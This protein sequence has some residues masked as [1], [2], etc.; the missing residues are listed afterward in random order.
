MLTA[1][2]LAAVCSVHGCS[3]RVYRVANLPPE[4]H[5]PATMDLEAINLS[6][7]ADQSISAEVIQPGDVLEVTMVTNYK[8]FATTATPVRVAD[9]GCIVVPLVG[10]MGVSGLEI[11]Q[12]EQLINTQSI[13]RGIFRN[14]CI[15][16]MMKQ[17]HTSKVTV[18]GAVNNPGTHALPRGSTSLM[19][20]LLAAGGLNKDA[21]TEVEIRHT[22]SR[23]IARAM[24]QP[25]NP[26][27]GADGAASPV[28]YEQAAVPAVTKVDLAAAT[29]GAMKVPDLGDGDVVHV[30][31]RTLPPVHVIGLVRT[32][33]EFPYPPD[34]E[35]RVLDALALAGGCSNPVAEK[36]LV[37]RHPPNS[38]EPVRIEISIQAAKNGRDN[39]AL[40][41]GDTVSVEQTAITAT[42]DVIRTFIRFSV[43]G[44]LSWF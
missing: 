23:S 6:G 28:A 8:E 26:L 30:S 36:V 44:T 41:P 2:L 27:A 39:L 20:A 7:L 43:G 18:V 34:Q 21:G 1:F 37:I 9:D 17:C 24:S 12:V 4:F 16:V 3:Q 25:H 31:K 33:G 29:V 38:A 5:A 35:L 19:A 10:R 15:T 13:A 22:D 32:P 42:A 14:P 40:A 11:E